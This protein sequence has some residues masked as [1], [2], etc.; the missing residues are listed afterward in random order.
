MSCQT[1][2]PPWRYE[3]QATAA[4]TEHINYSFFMLIAVA[5]EHV[6]PLASIWLAVGDQYYVILFNGRS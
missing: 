3:L 6:Q 1:S 2:C 5:I 4:A